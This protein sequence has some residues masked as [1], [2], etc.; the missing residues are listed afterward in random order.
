M[1]VLQLSLICLGVDGL[2]QLG[3]LCFIM[4]WLWPVFDKPPWPEQDIHGNGNN[5]RERVE[6][7]KQCLRRG[8]IPLKALRKLGNS[9]ARPH[10]AQ[11][12][13]VPALDANLTTDTHKDTNATDGQGSGQSPPIPVPWLPLVTSPY[14]MLEGIYPVQEAHVNATK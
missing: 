8:E 6:R 4:Y 9:V 3:Y 1:I 12:S 13:V 11:V 5:E 14:T 2:Q 10:L 7:I